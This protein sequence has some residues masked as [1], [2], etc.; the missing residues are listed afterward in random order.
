MNIIKVDGYQPKS[1]LFKIGLERQP[2]CRTS[3][4]GF[5]GHLGN[6]PVHHKDL[7]SAPA[8]KGI[9]QGSSFVIR[10]TLK[11]LNDFL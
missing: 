3:I 4:F 6:F 9:R 11:T 8:K 10:M 5:F 2:A 7:F 1:L